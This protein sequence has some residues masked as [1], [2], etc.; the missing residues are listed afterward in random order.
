MASRTIVDTVPRVAGP[1]P[2]VDALEDELDELRDR[3]PGAIFDRY[4]D[5]VPA[6]GAFVHIAPGAA[7]V[8]DVL[9]WDDVSVW[10][11]CVL[12]GDVNR[13]EVHERSNIQDGAVVHLG[14]LD[15]TIVGEEVVVG[16]RAVLHGCR[17][18]GGSLIGIQSTILD[19]A[20]IGEG[21]V[22][23]SG[24]LVTAGT[25]VPPRSLVLGVPGKVVKTLTATDEEFHRKLAGK[26]IRLAHNYREG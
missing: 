13:V 24:A 20:E 26:Y 17:I 7:I 16:H 4:L 8:G 21:S 22:I 23:G 2:D 19:G 1:P 5:K 3:F 14:D 11:G 15:P 10:Y 6:V 9:L 18:G 12:R 25:K